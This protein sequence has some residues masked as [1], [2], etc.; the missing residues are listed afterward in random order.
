MVTTKKMDNSKY[1]QVLDDPERWLSDEQRRW[2]RPRGAALRMAYLL[3]YAVNWILIRVLFR[4]S[5]EGREFLPS[6]RPFIVAPNHASPFDP[7]FLAAALPL[8]M[9]QETFWAGKQSTVLRTR[10]RRLLSRLT[11][12]IPISDEISA[13]SPGVTIL[14]QHNNLVW[15]PEGRRSLDGQLQEFKPGIALLLTRCHVPVVPVFIHGAA[16]AFPAGAGI[17]RLRRK[18]VVRI[19]APHISQ[20][21]DLDTCTTEDID[22]SVESLRQRMSQLRDQ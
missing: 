4:F 2:L 1:K 12:V 19:G 13:L 15:F 6:S 21:L 5:V 17:P 3:L 22:R 16:A 7:P 10:F 18:V 8:P 14:E 20:R 9:L 11:R